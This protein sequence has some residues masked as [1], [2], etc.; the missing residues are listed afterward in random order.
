MSETHQTS[1]PSDLERFPQPTA[2]FKKREGRQP[3]FDSREAFNRNLGFLS[4][5]DLKR[6]SHACVAIPG[7]G[8]VGGAHVEVLTRQGMGRFK[9]A[10]FDLFEVANFNRQFG[11]TMQT[12]GHPKV[13]VLRDR[14]LNINPLAHVNVFRNGI[15]HENMDDFLEGVDVVVDSLDFFEIDMRRALF[16]AAYKKGIPVVT[17]GPMGYGAALQVIMPGG[18][19]FDEFYGFTDD[20]PYQEKILRFLLGLSPKGYYLSYILPEYV[21]F[22]VRR[23]PSSS[24]GISL[25]AAM[26]S[27][28]VLKI[29]LKWGPVQALPTYTQFDVRKD[30][31]IQRR[32]LFGHKNPWQLIKTLIAR[33]QFRKLLA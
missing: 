8:G 31:F 6:L 30:K 29:V 33:H 19:T 27:M 16:Q 11:A 1:D 21:N 18:M 17:A 9:L 32:I 23:V 13:D 3:R 14:I 22:K 10:D 24:I 4:E 7:L 2:I 25:C 5:A 28:Q 26:A 12:V 20:M 15:T